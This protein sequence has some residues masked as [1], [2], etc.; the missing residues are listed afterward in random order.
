MENYDEL[1][2]EAEDELEDSEEIREGQMDSFGTFPEQEQRESIFNWFWRVT[3]LKEPFELA[4]VGNLSNAEIGPHPI[5]VRDAMNLKMLG[6]TFHHPIFGKYFSELGKIVSAS[7][8]AKSGWFMD[9]SISQKKVR[10]RK[11]QNKGE[12]QWRVFGKKKPAQE[13]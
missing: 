6:D 2:E 8:M 1:L 7:S 3:R 10:E 9:L 11:R 12:Q 4:K 13:Q 5:S